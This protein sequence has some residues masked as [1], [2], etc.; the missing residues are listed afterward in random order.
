MIEYSISLDDSRSFA[1]LSG[2][3]NPLHVDPISSRRTQFGGT[4]V[5]GVH[6]VLMALD[7]FVVARGLAGLQL[8]SIA[9]TFSNPVLTGAPVRVRAVESGS[10]GKFRLSAETEGRSAFS[11]Q[12][13]L[14]LDGQHFGDLPDLEFPLVNANEQS[15]PPKLV[16]GTVPLRI[17]RTL[18]ASLFPNL[19]RVRSLAWIADLLASTQ[20]VGMHCP[21]LY[22]I[23]SA[24]NL[25]RISGGP[26]GSDGTMRY[27]LAR[28][29]ERFRLVQLQIV[30]AELEGQ[31]DAFFRPQPVPQPTF[32]QIM[33]TIA[34][35]AF[36]KQR[37]LVVGGSRGL[38][39]LT[40][41]ILAAGGGDVTIT[42]AHGQADAE[43][44]CAEALRLH[45][46]CSARHLNVDD[47]KTRSSAEWI[48]TSRFTH[49]YYF[50]SP[51]ILR[52]DPRNWNATL[53]ERFC[54]VYVHAFAALVKQ[55]TEDRIVDSDPVEL[56]YPSSSFVANPES[57]FAEY[58]V[59]KA[60][61]EALCNQLQGRRGAQFTVPR[62]PR[63][64][65]D[66]NNAL[67]DTGALDP[68][69]VMLS[70]LQSKGS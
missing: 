49:I 38:G 13:V 18:A 46:R 65:T 69:P 7:R 52:S 21:G 10:P 50:A 61:G 58:A 70:L 26:R 66:Q 45:F 63:L 4:V 29:D 22:S 28:A 36:E 59:A 33:P 43:R 64:R 16:E 23:Y 54:Q 67:L 55:L 12:L 48:A 51:P 5:H 14:A 8:L 9:A 25:K 1:R 62:L 56:L 20:V 68:L 2:D 30:G 57:G 3:S 24:F 53:F 34:D 6:L 15:F 42:Y 37:A 44:V 39:E 27:E 31:L 35:H 32:S 11:V 41:K 40:A 60:A 47:L 17:S 19:I